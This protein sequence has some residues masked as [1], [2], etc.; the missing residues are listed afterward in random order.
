MAASDNPSDP[1]PVPAP[2]AGGGLDT[3][4]QPARPD[5]IKSQPASY[6]SHPIT[7]LQGPFEESIREV[8]DRSI[9]ECVVDI[10]AQTRRRDLLENDEYERLC[11]RKWP[12]RPSER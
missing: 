6:P 1:A 12:Q 5:T 7:Q 9:A 8:N 3:Q 4:E 2:D 10:D 11:G